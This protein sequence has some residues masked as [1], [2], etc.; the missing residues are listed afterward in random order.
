MKKYIIILFICAFAANAFA[1]G[2]FQRTTKGTQ[3]LLYTHNTGDRIK[4]SDIVT[5]NAVQKTEKDS[6]LFNS[7]KAGAPLQAQ[8]QE[9]GDLM[10]IFPLLTVKDSVMVKIP[11]DSIFKNNE[12][13]R[14]KFLP[15]GSNMYF[16]LKIEK[17]QSLNDA[18]IERKALIDKYAAEEAVNT[19]KYIAEHKLLFNTTA[20]GLKYK[21]TLPSIK[22]K[23]LAGDTVLVNYTGKTL[24][25]KIFDTS[26]Q[27]D[28]IK[29]GVNNPGRNYEPIQFIVGNREVISGWDEGFLLLNEGSKAQLIIPS[30]IGYGEKG[31]GDIKPFSTLFF[32]VQLVKIKPKKHALAKK[33]STKKPVAKKAGVTT[34][35]K[36]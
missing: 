36:N 2:D 14:P 25:G 7:Y 24:D 30:K 6:I 31:N 26:I 33:P 18:I 1:Q 11:T 34:K 23:P 3:Y 29:G 16:T 17:V 8:I 19:D 27:A 12:Q 10:D 5:F 28:A 4:L 22:R 15:K 9:Q 20:S 32:D 35:K 13:Q 21:V